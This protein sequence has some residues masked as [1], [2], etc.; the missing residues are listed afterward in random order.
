MAANLASHFATW[1]AEPAAQYTAGQLATYDAAIYIGSTYD[2][3]LP[4][5]WLDDVA[6]STK[7]VIWAYDNIWRLQ[8]RIDSLGQTTF[9]AKYGAPACSVGGVTG[10]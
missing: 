8:Q 9:Q 3:P 10:E 6:S 1:T 5:A 7:P 2:E 4:N